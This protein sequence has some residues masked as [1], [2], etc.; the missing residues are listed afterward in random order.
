MFLHGI[1]I[2]AGTGE[3]GRDDILAKW[4]ALSDPVEIIG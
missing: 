1:R 3:V 2:T 4:A